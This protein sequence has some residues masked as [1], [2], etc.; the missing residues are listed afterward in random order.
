[1]RTGGH[2]SGTLSRA[3]SR[4]LVSFL[5]RALLLAALLLAFARPAAASPQLWLSATSL[6][7]GEQKVGTLSAAQT[8]FVANTG[9]ADLT[10]T[11]FT[12]GGEH[13]LDYHFGFNCTTL[14]PGEGCQVD[15]RFFPAAP[16]SRTATLT[17]SSTA[18]GSPHV[19]ALNGIG[20]G[21]FL[22]ISPSSHDFGGTELCGESDL[23]TFTLTNT[24]NVPLTVDPPSITGPDASNFR[25]RSGSSQPFTLAPNQSS[26]FQ[27]DLLPRAFG[28]LSAA[29]TV[30]SSDPRSPHS[31]PLTG[32]VLAPADPPQPI[33]CS[34]G[35]R[36]NNAPG[37][38]SATVSVGIP[39]LGKDKCIQSFLT[40]KGMRSDGQEVLP[41]ESY[42][43]PLGTTT[44][45]WT[46][47]DPWGRQ[48]SCTQT[49]TVEDTELP[50]I[51]STAQELAQTA[52]ADGRCQ[53]SVPDLTGLLQARDNCSASL[54]VTQD[55]A[56]GT[57]VGLGP[58]NI[59]VTVTDAAG[60][61]STL[62]AT[63]TVVDTTAPS[64]T[65]PPNQTVD[66]TAFT[67]AV[68][69]FALTATDN[70]GT[71]VTVSASPPSGAIFPVGTTTVNCMATD[72]HG[73]TATGSF[74]V[75]VKG[76]TQRVLDAVQAAK[77]QVTDLVA[78]GYLSA[79]LGTTLTAALNAVQQT[80]SQTQV[81]QEQLTLARQQL[82]T[83]ITS[84]KSLISISAGKLPATDV[85]LQ[86]LQAL[87]GALEAIAQAL[88]P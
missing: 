27:V 69:S 13:P 30:H 6:S 29:L 9:D 73:N 33:S 64:L 2:S 38:C 41:F 81:T 24:G 8:L 44:I 16:G 11:G 28:S 31:V 79:S 77:T 5:G 66:T 58:T 65:L 1:M 12:L 20:T 83:A 55:P 4:A 37:Q 86:A 23:Q 21:P 62:V 52:P 56:P 3:T 25:L 63:F 53:A 40:L 60:N 85:R 80:V 87:L 39:S 17:V 45:T 88:G 19:V 50:V 32:L 75:T 35:I 49:V 51:T 18:P 54:T 46:A 47:T 74:T 14:I 61:A 36:V 48:S 67:G 72:A 68:V 82:N 10:F 71:P 34:P 70:C 42:L 26:N 76:P 22:T 7:F 59:L 15:L 57:L 78:R 43:F 84:L